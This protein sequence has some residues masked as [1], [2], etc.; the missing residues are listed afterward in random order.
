MNIEENRVNIC[1]ITDRDR[2]G[3]ERGERD[4]YEI[5][6]TRREVR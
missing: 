1:E 4:I 3:E 2:G 6:I 5:E